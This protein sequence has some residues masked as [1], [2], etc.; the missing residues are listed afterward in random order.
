M[1][2]VSVGG[3]IANGLTVQASVWLKCVF[4]QSEGVWAGVKGASVC[5]CVSAGCDFIRNTVARRDLISVTTDGG[6]RER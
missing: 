4:W 1:M 2:R 3:V 5:M 6:C